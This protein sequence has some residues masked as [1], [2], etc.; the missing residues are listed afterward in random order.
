M[1]PVCPGGNDRSQ[2]SSRDGGTNRSGHVYYAAIGTLKNSTVGFK[3]FVTEEITGSDAA[4][5]RFQVD[6]L[7][8]F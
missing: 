8:K 5:D 2:R 4:V 1:E 3:W 7:T 6:W